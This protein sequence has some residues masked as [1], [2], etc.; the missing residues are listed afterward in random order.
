MLQEP[1]IRNGII[2]D[3]K[4]DGVTHINVYTGGATVVGR[5]GS[6][7]YEAPTDSPRLILRESDKALIAIGHFKTL[8]GTWWWLSGGMVDDYFRTCSGFDARKRGSSI[9]KEDRVELPSFKHEIRYAIALKYRTHPEILDRLLN[10]TLP[11]THYYVFGKKSANPLVRTA[12]RSMWVIKFL[13]EIRET[14]GE[15]INQILT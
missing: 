6:N 5:E 10:S 11:L 2:L 13:E 9:P 12:D 14:K 15:V 1:I 7:L 3:P 8:E 4:K